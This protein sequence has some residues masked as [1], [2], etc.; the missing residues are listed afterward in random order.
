MLSGAKESEVFP[1]SLELVSLFSM[2]QLAAR[3]KEVPPVVDCD[4]MLLRLIGGGGSDLYVKRY[5]IEGLS[6]VEQQLIQAEGSQMK[7]PPVGQ[8]TVDN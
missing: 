3:D 5:L 6:P 1:L 2:V 8:A 4:A 7:G